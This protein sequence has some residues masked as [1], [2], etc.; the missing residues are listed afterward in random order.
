[1]PIFDPCRL[2]GGGKISEYIGDSY[3]IDNLRAGGAYEITGSAAAVFEGKRTNLFAA[4][5]TTW[6]IDQHRSGIQRPVID[7]EVLRLVELK[8]R[9]RIAE[10]IDRFFE[11]LSTLDARAD[12]ALKN[13]GSRDKQ[14]DHD[15][16]LMLSWLE[17]ET[18]DELAGI[19]ALLLQDNLVGNV[20]G[21][22]LS[23]YIRLTPE[24]V[25]RLTEIQRG[26]SASRQAFIAM[27]FDPSMEEATKHG[28]ERGITAA[29]YSPMRIDKKEHNNKIDDEIVAEIRRS[30]FIVADFTSELMFNGT[31]K[32][33]ISRGG[34]YF[35]AGFA[36]GL[37]LPVIWCCRADLIDYVHFDTRQFA[38]VVWSTPQEL[39][40][41]LYQ[42]ISAVI[43]QT[44]DAPGL[45]RF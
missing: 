35:E 1:M 38:H 37:G 26:G 28:F 29:G 43:G 11:M 16:E 33:A 15:Q 25:G 9:L 24:G 21:N 3:R 2:W 42:R 12:F 4:K 7:T 5:L 44:S 17:C 8:S 30:K 13:G 27:W 32:A 34:V 40:E 10:Q 18:E 20:V 36:L 6:I 19:V 45:L 23:D 41:K 31:K 14:Y 39:A 22:R